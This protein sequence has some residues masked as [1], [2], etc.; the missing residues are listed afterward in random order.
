[1]E[2]K[3]ST[4]MKQKDR[5]QIITKTTINSTEDEETKS[6]S[7]KY[8]CLI[9]PRSRKESVLESK[10][11]ES[12]TDSIVGSISEGVGSMIAQKIPSSSPSDNLKAL[13]TKEEEL[14][15]SL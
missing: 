13:P 4:K 5:D 11:Q 10:C 12:I 1:M 15:H 14:S 6:D 3:D 2:R 9:S 8:S 7:E